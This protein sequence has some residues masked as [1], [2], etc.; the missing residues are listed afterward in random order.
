V[1]KLSTIAT[2]SAAARVLFAISL[3]VIGLIFSVPQAAARDKKSTYGRLEI[4][5]APEAY[6][7]L[8][9]GSPNGTTAGGP[10]LIDLPPGRHSIEI[11]FPAGARWV[12]EFDVQRGKKQCI[13][14]NYKPRIITIAKSPCPFPV[15]ISAP[16]VV[17]DG[18]L[19]TFSSDVGYGGESPLIYTWT[20]SPSSARIVSGAGTNTITVDTTGLGKQR[21]SAALLVDDGSGNPVCRQLARSA[22]N[23]IAPPP[24]PV[25]PRKFDEFP[26]IAFDD[27]KARLDN[28]AIEMQ[29]DPNSTGYIIV[30]GGRN[31]RP[32]Q[33]DKL[34]A[35]A[36]SYLTT[37]R[38][39]DSRRLVLVN[40]GYRDT[41]FFE[42]WI[43]P[44]GAEPPHPSPTVQPGEVRPAGGPATRPGS[45]R[46]RR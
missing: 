41:D 8:I 2:R 6:P 34:G 5:T 10:R 17:N 40:G 37:A 24:P 38:G 28:L 42:I 21:V 19:I 27:D 32:G 39:I 43:V 36:V 46:R 20:I 18:E 16:S 1:T 4:T 31:S 14:L 9:D 25:R 29:N 22:T 30:Y 12:R 15:N 11:Q 44:Q 45:R 33:A 23:V 7:I 3:V 35:R 26:S 13:N